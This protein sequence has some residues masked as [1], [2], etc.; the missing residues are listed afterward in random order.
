MKNVFLHVGIHKTGTTSIQ[1]FLLENKQKLHGQD[2]DYYEGKF[3]AAN[4]VEIHAAFM[5][6]E[7]LTP[8]K[9]S[10]RKLLFDGAF[11][12]NIEK[13][14][15]RFIKNNARGNLVF[16]NEGISY[17]RYYDEIYRLYKFFVD[18]E[19]LP[20]IIIYTRNKEEFLRSY[21]NQLE[22]MSMPFSNDKESFSYI[23]EDSWLLDYDKRV[24]SF[25][26]VFGEKSVFHVDYDLSMSSDNNVIPS[27]LKTLNL[28]HV[29]E[30][31]SWKDV[32]LNMR[33][34]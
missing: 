26:E 5:R 6:R 20:T 14:L 13:G 30:P 23:K 1:H 9:V 15:F 8:F 25:A 32:W 22:K 18:C 27:F 3:I 7:R 11:S 31:D 17:L 24:Q 4:H 34:K 12:A 10:N 19:C 33:E 28:S 21:K 16:S 2:F 29:F